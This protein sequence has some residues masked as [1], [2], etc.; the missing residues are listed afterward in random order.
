M[1]NKNRMCS[2]KSFRESK[3]F[4]F[5]C[6]RP[7][8][9]FLNSFMKVV[10]QCG[11]IPFQETLLGV[12]EIELPWRQIGSVN[13]SHKMVRKK[14]WFGQVVDRMNKFLNLKLSN[15]RRERIKK[16]LDLKV[17]DK[18]RIKT[19]YYTLII[20]KFWQVVGWNKKNQKH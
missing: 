6:R 18:K 19:F 12:L 17:N 13:F 3:F 1:V 11:S 20:L 9:G 7:S 2:S 5:I 8:S 10:L 15:P 4:V 16:K 14:M